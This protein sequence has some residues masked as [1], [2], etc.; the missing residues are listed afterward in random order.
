[1]NLTMMILI[2]LEQKEKSQQNRLSVN[3]CLNDKIK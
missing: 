3:I 2:K 1:M